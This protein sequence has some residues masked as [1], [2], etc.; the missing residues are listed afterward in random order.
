MPADPHIV[1]VFSS[2]GLYG[3]EHV[4]LG[5]IPAL[6]QSGISSTLACIDNPYLEHQ[7]L[8][9]RACA[10]GVPAA[11][12]PCSGR[13]DGATTQS[14]GQLLDR[15]PDPILH[16]HG[17]KSAFYAMRARRKRPD[18]PIV[19]TLHG[20]I[21]NTRALWLYRMLEL[22]M[23]RRAQQVCIVAEGM[24]QPLH[25]AGIRA[26]R[27]RLIENGIDTQRFDPAIPG[28]PR[29][30]FG[31]PSDA[32]VFGAMQRLSH[33]KNPLGLLDAFVR[34][35]GEIPNAWLIVVGDGP[36]RDDFERTAHAHGLAD[37]VR[38]LGAR[39]DPERLYPLFDCFVLASLTE[40]L[41]LALL[42]AMAC[43]RPV[44]A[45]AV[46]QIPEVVE[47]LP[48]L[49]VPAGDSDALCAAMRNALARRP[50][51]PALR[52][53]VVARYSVTRMARQYAELYQ[54]LGG[55]RASQA[56]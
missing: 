53:R 23:L 4:V 17:Y 48:A 9:E 18:T 22:W 56:A 13:L 34:I 26:D 42:E 51:V 50:P 27:I 47:D 55:R 14:L 45:S 24:R 35:A 15:H 6:A 7:L 29:G 52:Q 33:E 32:F 2:A 5:L 31:I 54:E 37:R 12:V 25:E 46:G 1:H 41:P 11:R 44:V 39:D 20:W 43:E 49:L 36:L 21:T 38:M 40:G 19:S 16:V 8:Y 3:A 30:D 28:Y 10:L